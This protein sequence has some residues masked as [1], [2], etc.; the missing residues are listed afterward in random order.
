MIMT[1]SNLYTKSEV[2]FSKYERLNRNIRSLY[3]MTTKRNMRKGIIVTQF[4]IT[5]HSHINF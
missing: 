5:N 4:Y 3:D 1:A 2:K